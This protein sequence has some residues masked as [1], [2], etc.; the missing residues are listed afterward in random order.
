MNNIPDMK[1]EIF[2]AIHEHFMNKED[3]EVDCLLYLSGLS[4]NSSDSIQLRHRAKERLDKLNRCSICGTKLETMTY[5]EFH[6]ELDSC[7]YEIITEPYCP[8][9]DLGGIR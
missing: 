6:D 9:C 8:N 7:P 4:D 2:E 1:M 3:I 5:K